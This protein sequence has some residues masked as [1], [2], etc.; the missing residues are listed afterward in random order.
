MCL[1]TK[2]SACLYAVCL[3]LLVRALRPLNFVVTLSSSPVFPGDDGSDN[4]DSDG[5]TVAATMAARAARVGAHRG[6][7]GGARLVARDPSPHFAAA[8]LAERPLR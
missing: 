6:V 2:L 4:D 7:G 1:S 3:S 8:R 5:A